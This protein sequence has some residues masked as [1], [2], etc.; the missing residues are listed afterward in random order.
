MTA[1]E[2]NKYAGIILLDLQNTD[3]REYLEIKFT[4]QLITGKEY[5]LRFKVSPGKNS[6]AFTDQLGVLLSNDSILSKDWSPLNLEPTW[7]TPKYA[8]LADTG[9]WKQIEYK[10]IAKGGERFLAIGNFRNDGSTVYRVNDGISFSRVAYLY[11]DDV[12]LGNCENIVENPVAD[13][14]VSSVMPA[15]RM[16]IPNIITPNGD[17]FNDIFFIENLPRYASL[18]VMDKSGIVV[19]K[20]E[21]YKNDWEGEGLAAGNYKFELKLPDGNVV[22]GS[23]DLVR[24][25]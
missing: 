1:S 11:I 22:Y 18:T 12:Y 24:K 2:G 25:K 21:N 20:N 9:V 19:Y 14:L 23:V 13:P 17:R 4:Q 15:G 6:Y 10:F 8:P 16:H 7:K 5:C 3:F